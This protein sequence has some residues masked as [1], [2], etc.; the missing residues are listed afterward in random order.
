MLGA[1]FRRLPVIRFLS[2]LLLVLAASAVPP[3]LRAGEPV[4]FT[5]RDAGTDWQS[6]TVH[7]SAAA[8]IT[9]DQVMNQINDQARIIVLSSPA[10]GTGTESLPEYAHRLK[11]LFARD[12]G[13]D[14]LDAA[15]ECLG[16]AGH[17]L[18]FRLSREAQVFFCELFVFSDGAFRRGILCA[19]TT[20]AAPPYTLLARLQRH[21]AAADAVALAPYKVTQ[22]AVTGFPIS[23][24]IVANRETRR[25]LHL[26][27]SEAPEQPGVGT[28]IHI[29]DEIVAIDGRA[30]Q[31]F[32]ASM[33][34]DS[35]LGRVFLNRAAGDK[36]Q[37]ELIS[38]KTKERFTVTLQVAYFQTWFNR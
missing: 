27:V 7:Q 26:F 11:R 38:A 9:I 20:A 15:A 12:A 29:E 21:L 6:F 4:A 34:H 5:L 31:E 30:S 10:P 25:V 28:K 19:S 32:D 36:V 33:T 8:Q 35:E 2:R 37:L 16:Y 17:E 23:F 24:R 3:A 18:H 1:A 22:D 14:L 13:A